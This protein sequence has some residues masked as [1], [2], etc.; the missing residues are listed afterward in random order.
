MKHFLHYNYII[1]SIILF[2]LFIIKKALGDISN[3]NYEI[4]NSQIQSRM[5]KI[6]P[7]KQT[8]DKFYILYDK[9]ILYNLELKI[10]Y[11]INENSELFIDE[12][13]N[14]YFILCSNHQIVKLSGNPINIIFYNYSDYKINNNKCSISMIND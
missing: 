7:S 11:D 14:I 3:S 8:T 6:I 13:E 1:N 2:F 5:I 12:E 10:E 9:G 4:I